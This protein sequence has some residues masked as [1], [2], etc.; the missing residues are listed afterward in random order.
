MSHRLRFVDSMRRFASLHAALLAL[1]VGGAAPV[2]A[3]EAGPDSAFLSQFRWRSVGPANMSGRVT[4]VEGIPGTPVFYV[5]SAAGGIW[6]TTNNGTSFRPLFQNERVVALGDIAV[7]MADTSIVWAGTGEEDSRNSISAGGGIYKSTDGG[8]TWTL[9]GLEETQT[10]AR[11]VIHPDNPDLVY[12]AALGHIWGSNE[13][14]GLYR[15][16][17]GGET[18]E[19]IHHISDKAGFV[20]LVMHPNDPSILFASSWERVRG[21]YFL[22]SGGP[23]SA[24]WKSTDSGDTWN[25][26]TGG[27]FPETEK[28]RIGIAIAHSNPDIMYAIV[29]ARTPESED[30]DGDQAGEDEAETDFGDGLRGSGLYRSEDGGQTWRWMNGQNTR[31]F[32]YSQVRVDPSDPDHVVWS[33]TPVR[34]SKDGGLTVGQTTQG[35]H[36]D[37]HALWWDVSNPDHYVVGNDGGIAITWDRGGN[38]DFP[39]TFALGQFYAVSHNMDVPYRVCGGLQDNG[40][41]CGP[42]RRRGGSITNHMWY[43]VAGGD[44]FWAPQDLVDPDLMWAESQ[45][46]N[47]SRI[48][49]ANGARQGLQKP[50]WQSVTKEARDELVTIED[51]AGDSPSAGQSARMAELRARITA[52]SLANQLRWNWNT[53]MVQSVHDRSVFY[54]AANRVLKSDDWGDGLRVISPDLSYADTMKIRVS[55]RTTGGITPDVTGAETYAT[56]VA[57]VESPLRQGLLYAGTDDGRLW[58]TDDDGATWVELTDRVEGVPA[59]TYV[60]RVEAS[61]HDADRLYVTFDGHRTNDFMPYVFVTDDG[62]DTFRSIANDLPTGKPDFLHVVREDP[63]NENL[64]FVG[65]D[66]GVYMSMDRGASWQKFM[67]GLPTV[68]VHDLKIHPRDREL[69]A[70][71]HGRSIWI[72]DIA[73]IAQV[74]GRQLDEPILFDPPPAL[75]YGDRFVGGE[76]VAQRVFQGE[77]RRYGAQVY[78]YVPRETSTALMAAAREAREAAA[79]A[80]DETPASGRAQAVMTIYDAAGDTV[81]VVTGAVTPGLKSIFWNYQPR[82]TPEPLSPSERRDSI[83]NVRVIREVADSLIVAGADSAQIEQSVQNFAN[84]G[85]RGGRPGFGGGAAGTAPQFRER[86]GE[87]YPT[88]ANEVPG[89]RGAAGSGRGNANR[90]FFR[91]LRDR[92]VGVGGFGGGGG[93]GA[94]ADPGEYTVELRLGDQTFRTRLEVIRREGYE[95]T[96]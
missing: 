75:Q 67:N 42:S 61:H 77:S 37:H 89:G 64:L 43:T 48:N 38:W 23:G 57:L 29:E 45:G 83:R 27:G 10:I 81:Q 14:R 40:T 11:I 15:T 7:A 47:M 52:D 63:L 36:V 8:L 87:N 71:T 65:S 76:S 60:S 34:F 35:V 19:L 46:G 1:L 69:I 33:S 55:T 50:T 82:T 24:L 92:G 88:R 5:A 94:I 9:M 44:G 79:D 20:D 85:R 54:S 93:G 51:E 28:G 25:E 13:E 4:D 66:L 91:A 6:K 32:Y 62:G 26:V 21:P 90:E 95:P 80:G 56:I 73:P 78:Y 58:K 59:G 68:P 39:N 18:W 86:P 12:V 41:W 74:A 84:R 31:P 53:P 22:Q 2:V 49:V 3:Q 16:S 17:D 72:V 96:P 70:G 30:D